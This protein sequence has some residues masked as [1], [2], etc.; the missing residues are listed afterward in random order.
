MNQW[1]ERG[2]KVARI[3]DAEA[4]AT[5][6]HGPE[7]AFALTYPFITPGQTMLDI[8][9]GTGLGALLFQKAGLTVHGLDI[10]P[11]MLEAC[12]S[13]GLTNLIEHD[14][15][16]RPYPFADASMDLVACTGVLNFFDDLA[17]IFQE[18]ARIM[19]PDGLFVFVVGDREE[20]EEGSISVEHSGHDMAM[21]RHSPGDV[22][23]GLE[24]A[25]LTRK[26]ALRFM[27]F[28]DSAKTVPH[29]AKAYLACKA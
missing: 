26:R 16:Q 13:K 25:G 10:S 15:T 22:Q 1:I 18:A 2:N 5:G 8:G 9:I 24:S 27:V 3:Y 28:M 12:K 7:V 17:P 20:H 29:L 14:L 21:Y 11:D 23:T 6:W 19:R 4:E